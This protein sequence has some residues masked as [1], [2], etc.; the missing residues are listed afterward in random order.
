MKKLLIALLIAVMVPAFAACGNSNTDD[1][2]KDTTSSVSSVESEKEDEDEKKDDEKDSEDEATAD[3]EKVEDATEEVT[4]ESADDATE[5][6]DTADTVSAEGVDPEL[7]KAI[8]DYEA[9]MDDF[10]EFMEPYKDMDMENADEEVVG[11]FFTDY[12]TF[13][14][15]HEAEATAFSEIDIEALEGADKA[16]YDAVDVIISL[17]IY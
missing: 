8:D 6:D 14:S 3:D 11:Q 7:K 5:A 1:A 17:K 10:I 12:M 9:L 16:Y 15:E 13:F 4:E 2:D